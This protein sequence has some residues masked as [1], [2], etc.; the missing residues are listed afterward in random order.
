[1]KTLAVFVTALLAAA[2]ILVSL[3]RGADPVRVDKPAARPAIDHREPAGSVA[4]PRLPER[5]S[6]TPA[7]PPVP[8]K[9]AAEGVAEQR[10][11]LQSQFAAQQ[12][13]ASWASSARE[14][15]AADLDK[16]ASANV[17]VRAVECRSTLCRVELA[18]ASHDA[19]VG[20]ME[21]WVRNRTWTG[22]GFAANAGDTSLIV[23]L[24]RPGSELAY[25]F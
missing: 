14:Q 2:V 11:L 6:A 3:S 25:A 4:T 10:A 24:G 21:Q 22:P 7:T 13:D 23:F 9:G 17:R 5:A 12:I 8:E 19:G 20:F 16:Y 15:L 1:M 18:T